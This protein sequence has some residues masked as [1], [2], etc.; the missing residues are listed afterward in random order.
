MEIAPPELRSAKTYP[1]EKKRVWGKNP[2]RQKFA[3]KIEP[4]ALELHRENAPRS[5]KVASGVL[6]YGFRYYNAESGRWIN[7]D[8]I[9][10][11]GGNNLYAMVGNDAVNFVD[12]LGNEKIPRSELPGQTPNEEQIPGARHGFG[13]EKEQYDDF[14]TEVD[15]SEFPDK[16]DLGGEKE[17]GGCKC[18]QKVK[19][20][21]PSGNSNLG[22]PTGVAGIGGACREG[23]IRTF[24]YEGQCI[25]AGADTGNNNSDQN[26]SDSMKCDFYVEWKCEQ[27][28]DRRGNP[29]GN[30][31]WNHGKRGYTKCSKK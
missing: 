22:R 1:R 2:P 16:R 5:T 13:G 6:Y 3:Y 9:E 23:E 26:F 24:K 11:E 20:N 8:L 10:E 18:A 31:R 7:R 12:L 27:E 19:N 14:G 17:N 21:S 30:P 15:N 25:D 4:Q 29:R 28:Y